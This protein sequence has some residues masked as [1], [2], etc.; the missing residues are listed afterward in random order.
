ML[1]VCTRYS[2]KQVLAVLLVSVGVLITTLSASRSSARP[3]L[4]SSGNFANGI[5]LLSVALLLS[6]FLGLAQDWTYAQYRNKSQEAS[7]HSWQE[8]AFYLHFMALPFFALMRHEISSQLLKL[9]GSSTTQALGYTIPRT[10]VIL[11]INGLTQLF[12]I[13]GV[14]RLTRQVSSLTVT[15]TLA[16]RKTASLIISVALFGQSTTDLWLGTIFVT[17]GTVLYSMESRSSKAK[18]KKA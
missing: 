16:L 2:A 1:D 3:A 5:A 4:A 15:L 10:Y 18:G 17:A 9:N 11:L 12:C 13:T 7:N 6:G 8:S 14:H